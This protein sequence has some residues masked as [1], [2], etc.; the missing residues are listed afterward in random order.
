MKD[1]FISKTEEIIN[2][3]KMLKKTVLEQQK[4]LVGMR[5]EKMKNNS[6]VSGIPASYQNDRK[7]VNIKKKT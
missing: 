1:D 3:N 4:F 2:E 5:R 7:E 6:F